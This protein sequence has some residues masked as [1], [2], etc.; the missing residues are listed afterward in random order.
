[1]LPPRQQTLRATLAWSHG[2]LSADQQRIFRRLSVFKGG[3]TLRAAEAVCASGHGAVN[4]G[5]GNAPDPCLSCALQ[6]LVE[7]S[8]VTLDSPTESAGDEP[9]YAIL[10]TI[11]EYGLELLVDAGEEPAPRR[12]H[13]SFYADLV[14]EAAPGLMGGG[15]EP[16]LRRLDRELE[17]LRAAL[18]WCQTAHEHV[19]LLRLVGGLVWYWYFRGYLGAGYRRLEKALADAEVVGPANY[20]EP[21][22]RA[23]WGA[24]RM[25][26]L[27]GDEVRAAKLLMESVA[28]WREIGNHRGLA[29][30]LTDLGQ[31]AFFRGDLAAARIYT[32][33]S[34]ARFHS[35]ADR[36]GLAL[37]LQHL[38]RVALAEDDDE[39]AASL[40]REV[41]AIYDDLDDAWGRGMPMLGLGRVALARGN[42]AEARRYLEDGL[43]IFQFTGERRMSAMALSRLGQLARKEG[44]YLR[45]AACY[46]QSIV[47]RHELGQFMSIGLSL[48]AL[49]ALANLRGEAERA[50]RLGGAAEA[51]LEQRGLRQS[52]RDHEDHE[53]L[54]AAVRGRLGVTRLA[55]LWEEGRTLRREQVLALALMP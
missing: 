18:D 51:L 6:S 36:W 14:E 35:C 10:E 38:G 25:A 3:C 46:Q 21:W 29:Y 44:D 11:R 54:M 52:P 53:R 19:T 37:A 31:V 15:R 8:L 20:P 49:A 24:G 17:N 55:A 42:S 7:H 23:L 5:A 39:G 9:R 2:L 43:T 34:V 48:T 28:R 41:L 40:Y 33:E 26:H 47:L 32:D 16:W 50:A 4:S 12:A 13:A 1:D 27:L 30:A 45:A 22:A